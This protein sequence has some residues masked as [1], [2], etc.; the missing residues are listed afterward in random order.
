MKNLILIIALVALGVL[1][2][3]QPQLG[4]GGTK[5]PVSA[6]LTVNRPRPEEPQMV[7]TGLPTATV[8]IGNAKFTL[9]IA[10]NYARRQAGLM[11]RD[12]MPAVHGM[13]F[14]FERQEEL[15]FWMKNKRIPLDILFLDSEGKVVSIHQ[16]QPVDLTGTPSDLPAQYA[17]ELNKDAAAKAGV[18]VG[19]KLVLPK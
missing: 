10:D 19:D 14:I 12:S 11:N 8:Q 3:V 7:N 4:C 1:A 15:S 5:A 16:M 18:K 9:E 13:L 17:I 6:P 2:I